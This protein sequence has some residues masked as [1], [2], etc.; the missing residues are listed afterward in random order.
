MVYGFQND[1]DDTD[2]GLEY[3][4]LT[5]NDFM[6]L[7]GAVPLYLDPLNNYDP[8]DQG[9]LALKFKNIVLGVLRKY[10]MWVIEVKVI[11]YCYWLK[12]PHV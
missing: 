5:G 6:A 8:N 9:N 1:I 10:D 2:E 11:K 3:N 4:N 12:Y 7:E